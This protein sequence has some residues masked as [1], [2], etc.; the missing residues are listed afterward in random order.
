MSNCFLTIKNLWHFSIQLSIQE[1]TSTKQGTGNKNVL[2]STT[3]TDVMKKHYTSRSEGFDPFLSSFYLTFQVSL[4]K[5]IRMEIC[6]AYK[7][8][9]MQIKLISIR[10]V[11]CARTLAHYSIQNLFD[12]NRF[13]V[14][15][16][17]GGKRGCFLCNQKEK[18]HSSYR[19]KK[20]FCLCIFCFFIHCN[21]CYNISDCILL[22]I[23]FSINNFF[24]NFIVLSNFVN[25]C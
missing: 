8:I 12:V 24:N 3:H 25:S 14:L 4:C 10:K 9:L 2:P 19:G 13:V 21:F 1:K 18:Y 5:T 16:G 15:V 22:L 17:M 7:F 20:W 23:L 6:S 11:I